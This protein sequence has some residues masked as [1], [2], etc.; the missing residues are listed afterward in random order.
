VAASLR[1]A[2]IAVQQITVGDEHAH[3]HLDA[4]TL[5]DAPGASAGASMMLSVGS[6]TVADIG[7]VLSVR[8]GGVPHVV[9]Q[10]AASV[11]GF[12]DDQSVVLVDGVKRTAATRW[13]ERLLIDTD[14]LTR[15]PVELNRAG[16][17]ELLASYT[18]TPPRAGR[19]PTVT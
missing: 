11:N 8:L 13:P 15:A 18:W 1:A 7:K 3:V 2:S 4:A 14:V 10:T 5:D 16:L 17:G 12:A 19:W 9:V 6:G